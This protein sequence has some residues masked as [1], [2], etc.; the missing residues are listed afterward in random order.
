[1]NLLKFKA[2]FIIV[3]A[4]IAL[5]VASPIL[6]RVLVYPRTEFFSEFAMLD[7]NHEAQNYPFDIVENGTYN[8]FLEITNQLGSCA[9]YQ[10]EVK[11]ENSTELVS[12]NL[13]DTPSSLPSLY[14]FTGVVADHETL[15]L[16]VYFG[17][18]YSVNNSTMLFNSLI[19]NKNVLNLNGYML[20]RDSQT[21]LFY[22]NLVFELW[23]YNG[24]TG[25]FQYHE[26]FV[27]LLLNMR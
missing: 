18:E 22:S 3:T 12:T 20:G 13:N 19:V 2:L 10:V 25:V 11:I 27:S 17:F 26:R 6:Q 1:M 24:T 15:E 23:I 14:N 21:D 9:L 16:P 7:F 8:V 4:I 5:L